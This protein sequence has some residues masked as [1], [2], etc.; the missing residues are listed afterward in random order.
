MGVTC[1]LEQRSDP[2][3]EVATEPSATENG[4]SH[5]DGAVETTEGTEE[6]ELQG[7]SPEEEPSDEA[8]GENAAL[9]EYVAD[10]PEE[11]RDHR[12]RI[13]KTPRTPAKLEREEHAATH[14]VYQP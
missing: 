3:E 10:E 6:T 9:A 4:L 7:M 2:T 13:L 8:Q 12:T 14:A 1:P 11:T 5:Q